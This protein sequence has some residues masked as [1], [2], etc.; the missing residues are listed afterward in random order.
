MV[1]IASPRL[2]CL[3]CLELRIVDHDG[4]VSSLFGCQRSLFELRPFC[5]DAGSDCPFIV[6]I[7]SGNFSI[8]VEELTGNLKGG[9]FAEGLRTGDSSIVACGIESVLRRQ[10][11]LSLW[12]SSSHESHPKDLNCAQQS[13]YEGDNCVDNVVTQVEVRG[14]Q[15]VP[16]HYIKDYLRYERRYL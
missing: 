3:P 5:N 14:G 8:G 4:N 12:N 9:A 1:L 11:R 15:T 16:E 10:L 2:G 13:R 7:L 6:L